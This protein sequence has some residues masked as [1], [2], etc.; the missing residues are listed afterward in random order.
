[1]RSTLTQLDKKKDLKESK[2][3][4]SSGWTSDLIDPLLVF[5]SRTVIWRQI[6]QTDAAPDSCGGTKHYV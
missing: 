2:V 5:V 4:G 6:G 3:E 1:M